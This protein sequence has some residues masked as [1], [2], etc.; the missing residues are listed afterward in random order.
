M[1]ILKL[2]ILNM[3]I[4]AGNESGSYQIDIQPESDKIAA[5]IDIDKTIL[6]GNESG[7]VQV[8]TPGGIYS[9]NESG[10]YKFIVTEAI[11]EQSGKTE[12][13][14]ESIESGIEYLATSDELAS[15]GYSFKDYNDCLRY[16]D[17]G[18]VTNNCSLVR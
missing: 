11:L 4:F 18:A 15:E 14:V 3:Y 8:I 10:A 9:G 5:V 13:V 6:K 12:F 2:L 17:M 1:F 7:A 16:L